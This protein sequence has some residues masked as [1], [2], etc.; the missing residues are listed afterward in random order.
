MLLL[1]AAP[2]YAGA[3]R[4]TVAVLSMESGVYMEAFSAFQAAY[5]GEVAHYDLSRQKPELEKETRLVVA[6]GGRAANYPYPAGLNVIDCLAPGVFTGT[7]A[8][9]AKNVKISLIPDF[10]ITFAKL[11]QIQPGLKRLWIFWVVPETNPYAQT[12]RAEGVREGIQ[13]TTVRLE[14]QDALPAAL[15]RT[16]GAAD[17]IWLAP[18]PQIITPQTLR[19]LKEFSWENGI[20]FYG[21]TKSMTREGA[22]ASLGVSF[23]EMGKAAA[24]AALSLEKGEPATG[25]V[26]PGKVEITLNAS[27]A[28]KLG[29]VFPGSILDEAGYLFP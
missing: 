14:N 3:P 15:R 10:P 5:G 21:S 1:S 8:S 17:A 11:K 24:K 4:E 16:M 6:F 19:L 23:A 29:I 20:P 22:V 28:A 27:A 7:A 2:G 25:A 9:G 18:D 13:V 12:V 26:F